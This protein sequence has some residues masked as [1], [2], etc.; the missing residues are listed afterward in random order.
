MDTFKDKN[1]ISATYNC[2]YSTVPFYFD[3]LG[4]HYVFGIGTAV[5]KNTESVIHKV[6]QGENL[7]MLALKYYNNPTLWWAI[8]YF[9]NFLDAFEPLVPD[10]LL[11]I[12]AIA[13][14][15]FGADR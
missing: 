14:L 1:Y 15:E 7:D 6:R 13:S 3:T 8:A 11:K 10:T 5:N 4:G 2:R 12:P 9:N